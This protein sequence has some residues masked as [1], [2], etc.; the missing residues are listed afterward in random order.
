MTPEERRKHIMYQIDDY[1]DNE[2][3]NPDNP[4]FLPIA[5]CIAIGWVA[6]VM[7]FAWVVG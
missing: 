7:L 3:R 5:V 1:H 2:G 4:T 6:A